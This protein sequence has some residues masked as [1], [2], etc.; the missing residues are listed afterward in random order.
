MQLNVAYF[1]K[2]AVFLFKMSSQ[3]LFVFSEMD[4]LYL[5]WQ[6]PSFTRD[7]FRSW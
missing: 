4:S 1:H 6:T 3:E 5:H 7:V 2:V